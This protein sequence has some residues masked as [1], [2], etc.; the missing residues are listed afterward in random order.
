MLDHVAFFVKDVE[1][2][3]ELLSHFGYKVK[4]K[5]PHHGGSIEVYCD[6]Q[7]ELVIELCT[8]REDKGDKAGFN[9]AC[10]LLNGK[11]EYDELCAQGVPFQG[12][13][14]FSAGSGRYI[15]NLIDE[16]GIKWQITA[17]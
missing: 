12:N 14:H 16:D 13:Y 11:A 8:I 15:D 1:K 9:H 7:P 10:F 17:D 4:R 6:E 2:T 3:A 5:T